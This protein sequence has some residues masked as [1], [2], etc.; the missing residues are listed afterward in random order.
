MPSL[1]I[2]VQVLKP[3]ALEIPLSLIE[4]CAHVL[5]GYGKMDKKSNFS[6]YRFIKRDIVM[7]SIIGIIGL[8]LFMGYIYGYGKLLFYPTIESIRFDG[9]SVV[10]YLA[11]FIITILPTLMEIVEAYKW[12]YSEWMD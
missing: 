4:D 2:S 12:K 6:I 9:L 5:Y 1:L 8:F 7:I 3:K 11:F 10:L